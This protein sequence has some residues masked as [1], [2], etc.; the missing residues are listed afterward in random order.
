MEPFVGQTWKAQVPAKLT[1]N[2]TGHS[3][4]CLRHLAI[5]ESS[6]VDYIILP[7]GGVLNATGQ[8]QFD[9]RDVGQDVEGL[10][11]Y[12]AHQH[13]HRQPPHFP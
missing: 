11:H 3:F 5:P 7:W 1:T 12:T 13:W 8:V 2:C 4:Y 6:R 9:K 10:K